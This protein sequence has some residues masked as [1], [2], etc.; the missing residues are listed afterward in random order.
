MLLS[1]SLMYNIIK[2]FFLIC[3][4]CSVMMASV[5][6]DQQDRTFVS[7]RFKCSIQGLADWVMDTSPQKGLL[8]TYRYKDDQ[9]SITLK[10]FQ[11][12]NRV[13]LN[14][15]ADKISQ[16]DF[17]G[18]VKIA[19]KRGTENDIFVTGASDKYEAIYQKEQLNDVGVKVTN[20]AAVSFYLKDQTVYV[21]TGVTTKKL[22]PKIKKDM[23]KI[24]RSFYLDEN[25]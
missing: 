24:M 22:F 2:T 23:K 11:M 9:S 7:S 10:A 13:S 21:I 19:G 15:M 6:A 17:N 8:V 20:I 14:V 1:L 16:G 4:I 5:F 3:C 12:D 25:F 18:W